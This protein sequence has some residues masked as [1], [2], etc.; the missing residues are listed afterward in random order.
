MP[1]SHNKIVL[2]TKSTV[3]LSFGLFALLAGISNLL[4]FESNYQFV[5]HVLAMDTMKPFFSQVLIDSRAIHTSSVHLAAYYLI[6][7]TEILSGLL[8]LSGAMTL[9]SSLFL[10]DKVEL[11]KSLYNAGACLAFALWY[12]GFCV[13]GGEWFAMWAN[14]WDGLMTAYTISTFLLASLIWINQR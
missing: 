6:I 2:L 1:T 8:C 5:R 11:A 3:A 13:I 10:Q 14:E 7:A 4:D 9:F 12:L